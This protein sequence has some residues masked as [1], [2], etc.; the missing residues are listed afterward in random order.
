[1]E[2]VL[3]LLLATALGAIIGFE[4]EKYGHHAGFRTNMLVCLTATLI[5]LISVDYFPDPDS[6]AR[7]MTALLTGVGFIG[8][9]TIIITKDHI[10]G[11]TT[12]ATIWAVCG[13]GIAIGLGYYS[14]SI[15]FAAL[16]FIFLRLKI[17]EKKFRWL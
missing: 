14:I 16:V 3:K 15:F 2:F 7:I 12:A 9:G 13:M 8:A 4:R 11:L 6:A 1:M 10:I 5:T 17:I